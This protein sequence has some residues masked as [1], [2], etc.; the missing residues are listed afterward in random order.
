MSYP[1]FTRPLP[2]PTCPMAWSDGHWD[3]TWWRATNTIDRGGVHALLRAAGL[4]EAELLH[5]GASRAMLRP[6]SD[7]LP[8]KWV[9]PLLG[10][11]VL[12]RQFDQHGGR[13]Q[14]NCGSRVQVK[15]LG[16]QVIEEWFTFIPSV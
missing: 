9:A 10:R 13:F 2:T 5:M 16:M 1:P 14:S 8:M 4:P 12:D 11:I 7:P 6:G 15:L 3:A